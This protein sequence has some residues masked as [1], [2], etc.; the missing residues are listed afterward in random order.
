M[1]R[2]IFYCASEDVESWN[3]SGMLAYL[4]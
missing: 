1:V 2:S 4:L 3:P